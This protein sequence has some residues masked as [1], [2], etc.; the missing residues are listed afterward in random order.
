MRSSGGGV[1]IGDIAKDS[2][3]RIGGVVPYRAKWEWVTHRLEGKVVELMRSSVQ[4][5]CPIASRKRRQ[6]KEVANHVGGGVNNPFD[7]TILRGSV[8]ARESQ[9]NVVG[10]KQGARGGVVKLAFVSH[11]RA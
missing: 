11:W 10:E 8:G 1:G 4:G 6:Q 3:V 9:L 5:L 2:K 7:S